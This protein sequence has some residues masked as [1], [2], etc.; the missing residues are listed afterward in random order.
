[1]IFSISITKQF[2]FNVEYENQLVIKTGE[3]KEALVDREKEFEEIV[4]DADQ[5]EDVRLLTYKE[6][7]RDAETKYSFR[8]THVNPHYSSLASYRCYT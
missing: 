2:Y 7:G 4:R 5:L 6:V 1:M 3:L 8:V